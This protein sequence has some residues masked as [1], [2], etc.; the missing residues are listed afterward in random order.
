MGVSR[1][2][3]RWPVVYKRRNQPLIGVVTNPRS[4]ISCNYVQIGLK[5]P[6]FIWRPSATYYEC[7][8]SW[9]AW[10][11]SDL[12]SPRP[13]VYVGNWCFITCKRRTLVKSTDFAYTNYQMH[14]WELSFL[15]TRS[16]WKSNSL[17]NGTNNWNH[18]YTAVNLSI[19]SVGLY[20]LSQI[21]RYGTSNRLIMR[22]RRLRNATSDRRIYVRNDISLQSTETR[23][24]KEVWWVSA[25][26]T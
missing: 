1:S 11:R 23:A 8:G 9:T 16:V 7:R 14:K 24:P 20:Q 17:W 10:F 25:C 12:Y 2:I 6:G 15:H 4:L 3:R 18:S 5:L 19:V 21:A 13:D 26:M 22:Q